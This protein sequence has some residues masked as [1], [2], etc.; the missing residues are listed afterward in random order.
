MRNIPSGAI[1][2]FFVAMLWAAPALAHFG[3]IIPSSSMVLDKS[4][5][6]I[7]LDIAFAHPFASRGMD[8]AKPGQVLA[9][10]N[11]VKTDL[12]SR[13]T[14]TS[15][16]KGKA[17]QCAYTISRPGVYVFAVVPEPYYEEAEK[18]YIIHYAKTVVGAF[19]DEEGWERPVGLPVEIVP[20]LRPFAN[21]AGN[22]FYGVALQDGRPLANA[23]VEVENLNQDNLKAVNPYLETQTVFTDVNGTFAFGIPW[24]GWWGFSVL[25]EGIHKLERNGKPVDVELGG[26]IWLE[27]IQPPIPAAPTSQ[28]ARGK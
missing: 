11:G 19:G 16:M 25:T 20:L 28:S 22:V 12:A 10:V 13:L 8:M 7:I 14:E 24:P 15:F 2:L 6:N 21:Y 1:A 23:I 18:R 17:W 27:F 4:A 3:V 9:V 5:A 26:V